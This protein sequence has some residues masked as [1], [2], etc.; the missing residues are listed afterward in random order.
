MCLLLNIEYL[1][2]NLF[3]KL[4]YSAGHENILT[5]YSI[6]FCSAN[7]AYEHSDSISVNLKHLLNF[8]NATHIVNI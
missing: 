1:R 8:N 5:N 2:I 7:S 4:K 6:Y 3:R